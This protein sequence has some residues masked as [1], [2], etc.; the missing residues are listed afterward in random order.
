MRVHLLAVRM[1]A[2]AQWPRKEKV[3]WTEL[4]GQAF[5]NKDAQAVRKEL[6][7]EE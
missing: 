2:V 5:A 1:I 4:Q 3:P 7:R 6:C